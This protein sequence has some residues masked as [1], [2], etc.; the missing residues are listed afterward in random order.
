MSMIVAEELVDAIEVL[1][2]AHVANLADQTMMVFSGGDDVAAA[3]GQVESWMRITEPESLQ[4]DVIRGEVG[5]SVV[6]DS[7]GFR[8]WAAVL[9][10]N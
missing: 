7:T 5:V 6:L 3:V 2:Q 9:G 4:A 8:Q 1:R 10:L